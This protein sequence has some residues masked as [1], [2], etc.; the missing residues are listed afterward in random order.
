M[1]LFDGLFQKHLD[2]KPARREA[3][4]TGTSGPTSDGEEFDPF[5]GQYG[6]KKHDPNVKEEDC[7]N[8]KPWSPW[9]E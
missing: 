1:G 5:T 4:E 7:D 9:N 6:K 3:W 8:C 2:E